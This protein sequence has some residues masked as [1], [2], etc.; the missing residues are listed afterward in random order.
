[1]DK[2]FLNLNS[3]TG[4][5]EMHGGSCYKRRDHAQLWKVCKHP[6]TL[7]HQEAVFWIPVVK[8]QTYLSGW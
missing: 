7:W 5:L 4:A 2:P 3:Y 6:F 8:V 1:M